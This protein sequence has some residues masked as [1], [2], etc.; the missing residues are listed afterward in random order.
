MLNLTRLVRSTIRYTHHRIAP[1]ATFNNRQFHDEFNQPPKTEVT[2]TK[3]VPTAVASRY[4]VFK[5]DDASVILDVDEERQRLS[6]E[7]ELDEMVEQTLSDIYAGLNME[8]K[9]SVEKG[10]L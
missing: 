6:A 3:L 9:C 5:D 2:A 4:Q 10:I 1:T 8:R 7:G